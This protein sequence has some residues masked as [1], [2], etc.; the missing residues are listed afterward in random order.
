M[1]S[2]VAEGKVPTE[3]Q[4]R[5]MFT[6]AAMAAV[7]ADSRVAQGLFREAIGTWERAARG[8]PLKD[9]NPYLCAGAARVYR[10]AAKYIHGRR[11]EVEYRSVIEQ[12]TQA[13]QRHCETAERRFHQALEYL[14]ERS[15]ERPP[16]KAVILAELADLYLQFSDSFGER[17][18]RQMAVAAARSSNQISPNEKATGILMRLSE[19]GTFWSEE[20]QRVFDE[21]HAIIT[22]R[23]RT[24]PAPMQLPIKKE[25]APAARA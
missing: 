19:T 21:R 15:L 4:Y 22:A 7:K 6:Q 25:G 23:T 8:D 16:Q 20:A 11:Q 3:N 24:K 5:G 1:V 17:R 13:A 9:Y 12:Y 18:A 14:P 10:V 2:A